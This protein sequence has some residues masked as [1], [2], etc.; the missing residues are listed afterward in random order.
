MHYSI[1]H[2]TRF[3]YSV[4]VSESIMETR[5]QPRNELAQRCLSF[6]LTVSPKSRVMSYRD[7]LGNMVHH[8]SV[9][10][11]H[12]ELLIVAEA[13][14]EVQPPPPLPDCL[15]AGDW[16]ELDR[17]TTSGDYW[18]TLAESHFARSSKPLLDLAVRLR[19]ERRVD[20]LT[21]VRELNT[22]MF[23]TFA[24]SQDSTRVDSPIDVAL[25]A[26]QGVC[27]DFAHVMIAL[28]RNVRIPARYVSGYLY[29]SRLDHDRSA[30][31]ATHAWVEALLPHFGWVGFDP[32]NNLLAGERHIRTAIGRDY[33]DVPPTR[34]VFKGDAE[35]KLGV[36]VTV[37][38]ADAPK[39]DEPAM[40]LSEDWS[41][42]EADLDQHLHDQ[43]QQQQQ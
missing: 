12:R 34:G 20:P 23:K 3:R 29:H 10:G 43:Q 35:T 8:F 21:L 30:E 9:P 11:A 7:F 24:Y 32:T 31:G 13:L 2:S 36:T 5:M 40:V 16:D 17:I 6:Q 25:Q 39:S 18:E 22:E 38:P 1:R 37:T 4:P 19:A 26:R 42:S 41:V 27:Q 33:A 28:L 15:E 14:V